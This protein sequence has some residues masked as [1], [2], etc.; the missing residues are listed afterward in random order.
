LQKSVAKS[1]FEACR[2]LPIFETGKK[3][4]VSKIGLDCKRKSSLKVKRLTPNGLAVA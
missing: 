1:L 3:P 4:P 2:R